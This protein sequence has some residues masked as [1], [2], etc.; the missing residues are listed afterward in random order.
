M[1][2]S[3][4]ADY[5]LRAVLDLALHVS[6]GDLARTAEIARRTAA[7]PKFLE[8][9][10]A[11]LRRAGLVESQRGP[12]GGHRLARAAHRI[13]A[14]EVWRAIDGP[15][16]LVDRATRR[17]TLAEGPARAVQSLWAQIENAVAGAADAVTLE[18]LAHR[19]QEASNVSDFSI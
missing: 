12:E 6:P 15:V 1:R 5:A 11:E 14:G 3:R 10:L 8:A 2:I 19:A 13:T 9:I 17:K 16:A 18:D 4:K 7:P